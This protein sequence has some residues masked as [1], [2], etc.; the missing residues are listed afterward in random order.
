MGVK[1][2]SSL[3]EHEKKGT[4]G[5]IEEYL[6]YAGKKEL[7]ACYVPYSYDANNWGI[8]F[9]E[10]NIMRSVHK[11][12]Q[13]YPGITPVYFMLI[14]F[15]EFA[16]HVI[17]DWR[18][19]SGVYLA[20]KDDEALAEYTAFELTEA[21]LSMQGLAQDV[22]TSQSS[23]TLA[24]LIYDL[25]PKTKPTRPPV[26]GHG[27]GYP[28]PGYMGDYFTALLKKFPLKLGWASPRDPLRRIYYYWN[29]DTDR[30]YHP[31]V[32]SWV[33]ETHYVFYLTQNLVPGLD[34]MWDDKNLE[35]VY[36]RVFVVY[37]STIC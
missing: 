36:G 7:L 24:G 9:I 20:I 10:P 25:P 30:V 17:E 4:A 19:S 21:I 35:S 5:I 27:I 11:L 13:M 12:E 16:H 1:W 8:Y 32:P 2:E 33:N 22:F 31:K 28:S 18:T 29:R 34:A 14:F 3:K 26:R 6:I 23:R 37:N 15:H